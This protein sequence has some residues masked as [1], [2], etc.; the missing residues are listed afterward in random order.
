MLNAVAIEL[1][2]MLPTPFVG[3]AQLLEINVKLPVVLVVMFVNVFPLML[4]FNGPTVELPT[5]NI[6]VIVPD[7]ATE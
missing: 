6:A 4:W 5:F 1:L 3:R 7:A 2:L